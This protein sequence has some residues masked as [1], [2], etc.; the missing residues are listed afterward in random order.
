MNAADWLSVRDFLTYYVA[1]TV[2]LI[3]AALFFIHGDSDPLPHSVMSSTGVLAVLIIVVP[4]VVGII[5]AHPATWL[6]ERIRSTH[7]FG[8]PLKW[9]I[10]PSAEDAQTTQAKKTNAKRGWW[11]RK[12][13]HEK[14]VHLA[15]ERARAILRITS[16]DSGFRENFAVVELAKP[17]DLVYYMRAYLIATGSP[18][19]GLAERA[20]DL[21]NLTESLL[22]PILVAPLGIVRYYFHNCHC[23]W[24]WAALPSPLIAG[25]CYYCWLW[26]SIA[27]GLFLAWFLIARHLRYREYYAKHVYRAFLAVTSIEEHRGAEGRRGSERS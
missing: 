25:C 9:A 13:L 4:Y 26:A 2:W 20:Y 14:A 18:A 8:D 19:G 16:K 24:S 7:W 3:D 17:S 1:G 10:D 11:K 15:A 22:L 23:S 21:M 5:M 12:P 27:L 6:M